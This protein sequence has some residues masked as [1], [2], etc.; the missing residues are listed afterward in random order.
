MSRRRQVGILTTVG[1]PLLPY[2][3]D[4]IDE[5]AEIEP[6]L[7][8]DEGGFAGRDRAIFDDRTA[9]AFPPRDATLSGRRALQVPSHNAPELPQLLEAVGVDLLANGGT[10]RIIRPGLLEG[11]AVVNAHPGLLPRYR[12]AT[13]PEWAVHHDDPVG[14]TAHFMDAGI[15]TGPIIL[16]RELDVERAWSYVEL[17]VAVYR[18]SHVVMAHALRRVVTEGLTPEALPLQPVG[19]APFRPIPDD[20]LEGVRRK[21]SAGEYRPR[22]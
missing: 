2:L 18:L 3:L 21:V 20:L 12:G 7:V 14:V 13:C 11:A 22:R 1:N 15:D 17:R 6:V 9:G 5:V 19:D 4:R 16:S 8:L 10:P